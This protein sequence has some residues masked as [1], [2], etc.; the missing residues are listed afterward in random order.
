MKRNNIYLS[1]TSN[2]ILLVKNKIIIKENMHSVDNYKVINK[3]QF[4]AEY[5][6]I[7]HQNKI[8]SNFL[9]DNITIIIDDSYSP[10]ELNTIYSIFKELYYNEIKYLDIKNILSLK[11]NEIFINLSPKIIK[12]YT[13]KK[14]YIINIYFQEKLKIL[15]KYLEKITKYDNQL[16]IKI[17]GDNPNIEKITNYLEKTLQLKCYY[18]IN[19]NLMPLYKLC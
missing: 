13:L 1:F 11:P 17:Y 5:N 19:S 14:T 7:E 3:E 9:T 10:L 6:Q 2:G 18:F 16:I 15:K 8:N 4:L 12:I